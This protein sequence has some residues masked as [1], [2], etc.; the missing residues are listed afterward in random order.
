[1]CTVTFI[2]LDGRV[3]LTSNRD[4]KGT[5][6]PAYLPQ[7]TQQ[8]GMSVLYPADG[9][10]GGTWIGTA[11]SG[12]VMVLL[13][14]GFI[15]HIPATSY[16]RSRGLIFTDILCT[17][18]AMQAFRKIDLIGIEPFTL[19]I[20]EKGALHECRWSGEEKYIREADP[21]QPHIWSS[22]TLYPADVIQRRE[23]W[24]REWLQGNPQPALKDVFQFHLF[25]GEGDPENSI[26]MNRGDEMFT[27][28]VTG[29]ECDATTV[30]MHY[31]DL[32]NGQ[33]HIEILH[34]LQQPAI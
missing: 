29:M 34:F 10:A 15:K 23:Q 11:A 5:R 7:L 20:W 24:F 8:E 25:G 18:N 22:V 32:V 30:R 6:K 28:S 3:L 26:R 1:M 14:G 31:Q 4:E 33:D 17:G 2:P 12:T 16:R 21:L 9:Q 13:N 27:V 19:I